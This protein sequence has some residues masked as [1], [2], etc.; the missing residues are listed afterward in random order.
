[1]W[2]K[3]FPKDGFYINF[4]KKQVFH[5]KYLSKDAHF[6]IRRI[7]VHTYV[8]SC[9]LPSVS[10]V[11]LYAAQSHL[12][13][14]GTKLELYLDRCTPPVYNEPYLTNLHPLKSVFD[15]VEI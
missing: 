1:M 2:F 12:S 8:C 11:C 7:H 14:S 15:G 3:T 9:D 13:C 4:Q 5:N 10:V 6:T